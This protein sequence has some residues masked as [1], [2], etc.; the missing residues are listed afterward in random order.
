MWGPKAGA[1]QNEKVRGSGRTGRRQL[2]VSLTAGCSFR[3]NIRPVI[4]DAVLTRGCESLVVS[5]PLSERLGRFACDESSRNGRITCLMFQRSFPHRG[6]LSSPKATP[7]QAVGSGGVGRG[8]TTFCF[9]AGRS[10]AERL[11]RG[12]TY[13]VTKCDLKAS[14]HSSELINGRAISWQWNGFAFGF[15]GL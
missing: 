5:R 6:D 4:P 12:E 14:S 3:G 8:V 13:E 10:D 15:G 7:W 11:G 9:L 1:T 2:D